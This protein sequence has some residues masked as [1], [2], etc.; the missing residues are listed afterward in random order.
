MNQRFFYCPKCGGE[1]AYR[2]CG[3]RERLTCSGCGYIFYENPVVGVAAIVL[4]GAGRILL[5]RRSGSYRGLWCIPCGYV[6][7]DEDVYAAAVRECREETGLDIE[8]TG[9]FAVQSN[10]HNPGQHTVGIWFRAEVTGGKL[11]AGGDLVEVGYF[12]LSSPPPLAFPTDALV[13][14]KLLGSK[15]ERDEQL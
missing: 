13:L 9:V 4:D 1:L 15:S 2:P 10:F 3:G 8:I 14:K 11:Q 5:G 6:E 7:Y 12:D